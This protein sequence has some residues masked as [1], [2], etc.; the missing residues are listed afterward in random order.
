MRRYAEGN[1]DEWL[2]LSAKYGVL[3]PESVIAPYELTLNA[4]PISERMQWAEMAWRQLARILPSK[5]HI[6]ILAGARY[7]TLLLPQLSSTDFTIEIPMEGL[8]M[9][10]Q[11]KWLNEHLPMGRD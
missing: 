3:Q 7:R 8:R 9:G 4:L 5:A 6:I 11:M 1:C 2:I 10:E